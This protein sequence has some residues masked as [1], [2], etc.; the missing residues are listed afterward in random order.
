MPDKSVNVL[1]KRE[2]GETFAEE[3]SAIEPNAVIVTT[4]QL[5]ADPEL[6]SRIDVCLGRLSVEQFERASRLKWLQCYAAGMDWA[7]NDAIR[8]HPALLTNSRIHAAPISEHLFGM[9]LM[10]T[11]RLHLAYERQQ[12][13]RWKRPD[14]DEVAMIDG[15]TL[16]VLGLGVIG[17]R[18]ARVGRAFGMEVVGVK[19]HVELVTDVSEVF[20][21]D[22]MHEALAAADV[23][24]NLL[25]GTEATEKLIDA[26]AFAAM[27]GGAIFMNAG[28][29]RT[30][31]TDALVEALRS[32]RL[33]G[34]CIDVA[35]PEPLPD[36]HPLWRMP[37]VLITAHYSGIH[38]GYDRHVEELFLENLRRFR[39][40]RPLIN[41][42][43]KQAGY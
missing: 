34:A 13:G 42:V 40:G 30:V 9:L 6:I 38:P 4:D 2:V 27:K 14:L 16:C 12:A 31:D 11:R 36:G 22:R 24:I 7:Q 28:R 25:P 41:L 1:V 32:G 19:R 8:R 33:F 5:D 10:L 43:D 21:P 26:G 35:A 3:I 20:G 23:V 29:G 39:A 17:R 37:N 15:K 18:C